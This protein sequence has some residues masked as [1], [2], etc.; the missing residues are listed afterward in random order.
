MPK[1]TIRTEVVNRVPGGDVQR[2]IRM[3]ERLNVDIIVCDDANAEDYR[4]G[5]YDLNR[6][7]EDNL[8]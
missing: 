6:D 4:P 3:A 7:D 5:W 8:Q 1:V 2:L